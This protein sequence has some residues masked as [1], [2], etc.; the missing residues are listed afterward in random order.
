MICVK[1]VYDDKKN[2]YLDIGNIK[3]E[4]AVVLLAT[5]KDEEVG[6]AII[7]SEQNAYEIL[8]FA[9][10]GCSDYDNLDAFQLEISIY[11]IKACGLYAGNRGSFVLN[12][13]DLSKKKLFNAFDFEQKDQ[14][15]TIELKKLFKKCK[16]CND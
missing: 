16:N 4:K 2:K 15:L 11:L 8:K 10:I 9:L 14:K 13:S 12:T 7:K 1:P 6:Y 5:F 3:D